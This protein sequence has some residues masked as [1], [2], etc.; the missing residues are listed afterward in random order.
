MTAGFIAANVKGPM[1]CVRA[2][3]IRL[4]ITVR[5][6]SILAPVIASIIVKATTLSHP[7]RTI[8]DIARAFLVQE[9]PTGQR[10]TRAMAKV[11][12]FA[13]LIGRRRR[14]IF[15]D[16][17][18]ENSLSASSSSTRATWRLAQSDPRGIF[19]PCGQV[20]AMRPC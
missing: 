18:S 10:I 4:R 7:T 2:L 6:Y 8:C 9:T 13:S 16:E 19:M 14:R 15:R 11:R 12:G 17:S 1:P 5:S 20:L 3:K